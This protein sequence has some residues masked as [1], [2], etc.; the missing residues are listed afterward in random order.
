[1]LPGTFDTDRLQSNFE[2]NAKKRGISVDQ[3]KAERIATVPRAASASPRNSAKSARFCAQ[4]RPA[5][6]PDRTFC[7]TAARSPERSEDIC[8]TFD[9]A[10]NAAT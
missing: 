7:S 3:A 1:M 8:R 5:I 6:L 10:R 9:L 2:A 4:H